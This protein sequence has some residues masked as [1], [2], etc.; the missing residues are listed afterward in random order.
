MA[1]Q[2]RSPGHQN[3]AP[4]GA[5]EMLI[6]VHKLSMDTHQRVVRIETRQARFMQALGFDTEGNPLPTRD[7]RH[8]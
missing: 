5:M 2:R 7:K 6:E 4:P 1:T 3:Q 8:I